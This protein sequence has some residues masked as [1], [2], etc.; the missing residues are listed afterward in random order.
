MNN[1]I[2]LLLDNKAAPASVSFAKVNDV[3]NVFLKGVI[4]AA[5]GASATDLRA[6]F[7]KAAG[8]DVKLHINS[9]GGEVFEAREM[10]AVIA[11]YKGKVTA[12]IEGIAASAATIVSMSASTVEMLKGSRYMIHNGQSI[13]MG[14]KA[15]MRSMSELLAAFDVELAGEY[16]KRTGAPIAQVTAW[17]A[18]ETW[19]NADQALEAKFVDSLVENTKNLADLAVWNVSAYANAPKDAPAP[20]PNYAEEHADC[21][22]RLR[23]LELT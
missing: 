5:Y 10:Q 1:L 6:A 9:P 8:E 19:F 3:A 7:D 4:S 18:A 17:M 12:V 23:I 13:A 14:D 20:D 11:G 22:R 16:S 2:K 21:M 15:A